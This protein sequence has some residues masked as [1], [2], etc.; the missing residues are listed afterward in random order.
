MDVQEIDAASNRG[1]DEIR[2]LREAVRKCPD[3]I[4]Q[5]RDFSGWKQPSETLSGVLSGARLAE[6]YRQAKERVLTEFHHTYL[7]Y[8]LEA[9]QGNVSE[10]ARHIGIM[11]EQLNALIRR[12]KIPKR[13]GPAE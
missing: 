10:T 13:P 2:E 4:L 7:R 1:I 11:R 3:R 5:V 12:F 6:P 8:H 9:H